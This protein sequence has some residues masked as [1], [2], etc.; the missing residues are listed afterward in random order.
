MRVKAEKTVHVSGSGTLGRPCWPRTSRKASTP[1]RVL[2]GRL[3]V[4]PGRGVHG[5]CRRP[6]R[7]NRW[8]PKRALLHAPP[9]AR[10][11]HRG[12]RRRGPSPA[13]LASCV[14]CGSERRC[15]ESRP[16]PRADWTGPEAGRAG[17]SLCPGKGQ[18]AP[19]TPPGTGKAHLDD[20]RC[21]RDHRD[22][23]RGGGR[24]G[25]GRG[26]RD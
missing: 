9:G 8:K 16:T 21:G 20:G 15:W 4:K 26:N 18:S 13:A 1:S 22:D 14:T 19:T 17:G 3:P 25:G 23:G 5:G 24:W 6:P 10:L 11:Y 7:T 2:Q 12:Q